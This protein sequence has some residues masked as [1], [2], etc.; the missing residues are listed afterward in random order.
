MGGWNIKLFLVGGWV[1]AGSTGN[2]TNSASIEV[3][4]ELNWVEAELGK[5]YTGVS[6]VFESSLQ[7]ISGNFQK[8]VNTTVSKV[9]P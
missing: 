1:G 3:E 8:C 9:R 6:K 2:I 4:I 5:S 7:I